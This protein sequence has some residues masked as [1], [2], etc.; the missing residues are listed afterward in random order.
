[1]NKDHIRNEAPDN[2]SI[3]ACPF[4]AAGTLLSNDQEHRARSHGMSAIKPYMKT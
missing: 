1:M 3:V 2:P 4:I